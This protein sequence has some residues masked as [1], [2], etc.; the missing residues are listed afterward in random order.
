[1]TDTPKR[2]NLEIREHPVQKPKGVKPEPN[3]AQN[4]LTKLCEQVVLSLPYTSL[5]P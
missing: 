1:M 3:T 2:Q 5:K 4:K